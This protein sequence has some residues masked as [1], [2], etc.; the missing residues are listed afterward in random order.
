MQGKAALEAQLRGSKERE[1]L[2]ALQRD[3]AAAQKQAATL[4]ETKKTY[5][6]ASRRLGRQVVEQEGKKVY[7][8]VAKWADRIAPLVS[9]ADAA[10][11]VRAALDCAL[12]AERRALQGRL[13]GP[14]GT[15]VRCAGAGA[16][17]GAGG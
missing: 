17:A 14:G 10:A 15:R 1:R 16:T 3:L 4:A 2:D 12:D 6:D 5:M 11:A 9:G 8:A 13:F 7:E